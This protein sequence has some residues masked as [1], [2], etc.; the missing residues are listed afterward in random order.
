[1]RGRSSVVNG[2][3][4]ILALVTYLLLLHT[5]IRCVRKICKTSNIKDITPMFQNGPVPKS[6]TRCAG[7]LTRTEVVLYPYIGLVQPRD[8]APH[9]PAMALNGPGKNQQE[10]RR[11]SSPRL[12]YGRCHRSSRIST[13]NTETTAGRL[14]VGS[15]SQ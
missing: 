13:S 6:Y 1:M 8:R 3:C 5:L 10:M 15:K 4:H 7:F 2:S 9:I 11:F 12:R 14:F